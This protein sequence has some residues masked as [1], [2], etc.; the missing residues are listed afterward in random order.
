MIKSD[1]ISTI[2][3]YYLNGKC[4]DVRW[5]VVDKNLY[6]D[7]MTDDGAMLGALEAVIDLEDNVVAMFNTDRFLSILNALGDEI[8]GQYKKNRNN[9]IGIELSDGTV[10]VYFTTGELT[11]I[12]DPKGK[13]QGF[14]NNGRKLSREPNVAYEVKLDKESINRLLKAKKA[15]SDAKIVALLQSENVIDF[16]VNYTPNRNENKI[17]VPFSAKINV[18]VNDLFSYNVEYLALVLQTNDD[19]RDASMTVATDGLMIMSFAAEDYT[20]KYYIKS[21]EI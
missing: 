3:K 12:P 6:V 1:L 15:L 7:F 10:N 13:I 11:N 8:Q 20:V 4:K 21:L 18:D 9:T 14:R 5:E 16:V 19:F 2:Q 17:T